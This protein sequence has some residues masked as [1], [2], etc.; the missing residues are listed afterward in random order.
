MN[1]GPIT[2]D[3]EMVQALADGSSA[4]MAIEGVT[5][6][7]IGLDDDGA[8]SL[9]IM[10]A[11]LSD[12]PADVPDSLA[13]WPVHVIQRNPS[14]FSVPPD[15][16]F[17]PEV[18]GGIE[19]ARGTTGVLSHA[20]GTLG[21]V[22]RDSQNG[23][24]PVGVSCAHVL[25][26]IDPFA[27]FYDDEIWQPNRAGYRV[28]RLRRW[29]IPTTPSWNPGGFPSGFWDAAVCTMDRSAAVGEIADI[30]TLSGIA[31]VR[32]VMQSVRKRG[33]TTRLTHGLVSGMFGSI[34]FSHPGHATA[35]WMI[36]QMEIVAT[37]DPDLNPDGFAQPGDSGSVVVDE[38]NQVVGLLHG[39]DAA[40]GIG[41]A[42]DFAPLAVALGVTI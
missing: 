1:E 24:A 36:G 25:A 37:N 7:D 23:L 42:S 3:P 30:G 31:S 27:I 34:L 41:Y 16:G 9:R 4:L 39:G 8:S 28:G 32:G 33:C 12:V 14:L 26:G 2:V 22:L 18:V 11:D 10:V 6:F 21:C 20:P 40:S 19:V 35:W 13:G 17:Y 29:E 5:G 38:D 15:D